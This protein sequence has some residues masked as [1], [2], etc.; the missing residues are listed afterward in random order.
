VLVQLFV[1]CQVSY[2]NRI[3]Q[4]TQLTRYDTNNCT[5]SFTVNAYNTFIQHFHWTK[6][7]TTDIFHFYIYF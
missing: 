6:K 2:V 1:S 4:F 5:N 7:S 3:M